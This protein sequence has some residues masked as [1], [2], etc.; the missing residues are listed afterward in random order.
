MYTRRLAKY[1]TATRF[2]ERVGS[3]WRLIDEFAGKLILMPRVRGSGDFLG[4]APP[5][6][7]LEVMQKLANSPVPRADLNQSRLRNAVAC[8]IILGLASTRDG[9][10]YMLKDT[11]DIQASLLRAV[12]NTRSFKIVSELIHKSPNISAAEI[13]KAL[14]E[15]FHLPWSDATNLR[16]GNALR[17][18]VRWSQSQTSKLSESDKPFT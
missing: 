13:G 15:Q 3:E 12:T 5:E 2:L 1:L 9:E 4:D 18:W 7:V 10:V 11:K 6:R 17:K 8:A 16:R 14:S